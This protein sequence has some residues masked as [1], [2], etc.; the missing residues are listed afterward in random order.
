MDILVI[1]GDYY[2]PAVTSEEGL[3][4]LEGKGFHF[5][6]IGDGSNFSAGLLQKYPVVLF[7]KSDNLTTTDQTK[8]I[9]EEV[10]TALKSYVQSGGGLLVVHSGMAGFNGME[11]MRSL[12]G[13]L[14]A[15]HPAQLPVVVEPIAGHPLA[16]G[17]KPF[18]AMDEHYFMNMGEGPVDLFLTSRSRHGVVPAGW[19]RTEGHGRVCTLTPGHN[20]EVWLNPNFQRL[21]ENA[22]RWCYGNR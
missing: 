3:K 9:T 14:F 17:C 18:T 6:I 4:P 19:T 2:H 12:I 8:W 10:R 13:G 7:V 11:D 22:L 15:W 5:E 16:E 21:L 1:N 20:V